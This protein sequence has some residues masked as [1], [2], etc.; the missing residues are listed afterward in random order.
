MYRSV[1]LSTFTLL[2]DHHHHPAPELFSSS[3]LKLLYPLNC[4]SF[5]APPPTPIPQP[6]AAA[7][8]LSVSTNLSTRGSGVEQCLPFRVWFLSL[9]V[10]SSRF[11]CVA[12]LCGQAT[13]CLSTRVCPWTFM[14]PS[15]EHG[16]AN[17]CLGSCFHL[18]SC[19]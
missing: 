10:M 13:F 8:L 3:R 2:C 9:C 7:I 1:A 11:T 16:C 5:P 18:K 14:F 19:F 15:F 17:I 12:A 4:N 6:L